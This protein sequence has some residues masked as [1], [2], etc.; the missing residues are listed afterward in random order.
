[1]RHN[2]RQRTT[3]GLLA[4]LA[5]AGFIALFVQSREQPPEEETRSMQLVFIRP[6]Q[7]PKVVPPRQPV[8]PA[9]LRIPEP[10]TDAT[11]DR[12]SPAVAVAPVEPIEPPETTRAITVAPEAA[13]RIDWQ[14]QMRI[15][16]YNAVKKMEELERGNPLD[17]K[18]KVLVLPAE[19]AD[20]GDV[21]ATRLDNGDL[22]TE[23][24]LTD[25]L[26]VK[27]LHEHVPV[28]LTF[29]ITAQHLP[30]KCYPVDTS[31]SLAP[32]VESA[33]PGYLRRPLPLPKAAP[34]P[35]QR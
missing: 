22:V 20:Q 8:T 11:S 14:Q 27:C 30:P 35:A 7:V 29:D 24:R 21:T 16:A 25:R 1:M 13:P 2:L 26:T 33:R 28:G 15:A 19:R 18:P 17:S 6:V 12:I 31:P 4:L 5:Q 34:A 23:H 3:A 9:A 10:A 32:M